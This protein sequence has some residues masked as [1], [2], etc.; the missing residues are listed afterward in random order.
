MNNMKGT[1]TMP[2]LGTVGALDLGGASSQIT[3]SPTQTSVL[4]DFYELPLGDKVV[5]LYS[6]SFLG[7]GWG[8]ARMVK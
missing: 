6:H 1:L 5:R 8:D 2:A 4:E 3:F 7:Y